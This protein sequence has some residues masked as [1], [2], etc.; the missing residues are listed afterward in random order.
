MTNVINRRLVEIYVNPATSTTSF[1]LSIIDKD[2]Q[3]FIIAQSWTG[4]YAS[5]ARGSNFPEFMIGNITL[6]IANAS[7]NE[8][9]SV[10]LTFSEEAF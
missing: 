5:A 3:E 2:S 4:K 9:F 8:A 1:D 10:S 6:K 7:A